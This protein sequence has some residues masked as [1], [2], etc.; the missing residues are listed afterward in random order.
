MT[1]LHRRKEAPPQVS[2]YPC[3]CCGHLV[4]DEP[5]GSYALCPVCWWED[6]AVQLRWPRYAGG[7][8]R[9]SLVEAQSNFATFAAAE[10]AFVTRVRPAA[11]HEPL[12]LGFH[13]VGDVLGAFE[14]P[15]DTTAEWPD[16]LTEL[17]WWKATFWR[18]TLPER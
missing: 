9:P 1:W 16:D 8:N 4:F 12:D 5:P 2:E 18:G 14:E 13:P 7:A 15:G 17:Y 10:P 6:D 3:P 11:D